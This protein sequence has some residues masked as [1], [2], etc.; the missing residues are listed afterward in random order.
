MKFNMSFG[1]GRQDALKRAID[2]PTLNSNAG[3]AV[4][5][6]SSLTPVPGKQP[7]PSNPQ[8]DRS[9]WHNNT[10]IL[11]QPQIGSTMPPELKG[12]MTPGGFESTPRATPQNLNPQQ[13]MQN[14]M[15]KQAMIKPMPF[16]GMNVNAQ[17]NRF[18]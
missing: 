13:E 5:P 3:R 4:T 7:M 15:N 10:P 16:N 9:T 6:P 2:N 1:A 8:D 14:Q 17:Q 11:K 12:G 18:Q